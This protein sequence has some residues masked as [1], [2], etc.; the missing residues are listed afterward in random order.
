[1]NKITNNK[2]GF[3]LLLGTLLVLYATSCKDFLTEEMV[4]SRT[5]AI[6]DTEEGLD[7]LEVALYQG[8]RFFYGDEHSYTMTNYGTD[9][10][11]VGG[12]TDYRW[13]N[14]YSNINPVDPKEYF[15]G[16]TGWFNGLYGHINT[17]NLMLDRAD[18]ILPDG[19][20]KS[21]YKG[22]AYFLRG[23]LYFRLL[24]QYGGVP[25]KLTPSNTVEY[26]FTRNTEGE[27]FMQIISDLKE[28][29]NLLPSTTSDG[30]FNKAAAWHFLAKVYLFRSSE[31]FSEFTENDDL[32]NAIEYGLKVIDQK[33]ETDRALASNYYDIWNYLEE[34][35][36][37]NAEKNPE[38]ILSAQYSNDQTKFDRLCNRTHLYY[39]PRYE[40]NIVGMSRVMQYGRP[41]Q[42]L[43]PT[44]YTYDVFDRVNDSR[45][46]KSFRT[47]YIST[48]A[49]EGVDPEGITRTHVPGVT[50]GIKIIIND[51][52]DARYDSTYAKAK[53]PNYWLRHYVGKDG[54]VATTLSVTQFAGLDKFLDP[55]RTGSSAN[56]INGVR[57][58]FLARIGETYL[59]VAEAYGRSGNYAKAVEYLNVLRRRAG[60]ADNESRNPN[61]SGSKPFHVGGTYYESTGVAEGTTTA[62]KSNM[63]ITESVFDADQDAGIPYSIFGANTREQKFIHFILNERSREL[64]GEFLRW[65]DLSRTKTLHVRTIPFNKDN[66]DEQLETDKS[67]GKYLLRP[68]PQS[69]LDGIQTNGSPLT[70]EEKKAMQ[71]PGY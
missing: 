6:F 29:A 60:Y 68:I 62:T 18:K 71:N 2:F 16:L 54:E 40:N 26:E 21:A 36:D 55:H 35:P 53:F 59:I 12:G 56:D 15:S 70:P 42:R 50:A 51:K 63:E 22:S 49:A 57:D 23:F 4:S 52:N 67:V 64:M 25:L 20:K 38:I 69:F 47:L 43:R 19:D 8:L 31:R 9:E 45:F 24:N 48:V 34:G 27:V 30:R 14:D 33:E 58:G 10:F 17:A 28:A 5:T 41:Y 1:M 46:W 37:G 61:T 3:S 7:N 65:E 44:E 39:L 66:A 13:M 32:T 11:Q